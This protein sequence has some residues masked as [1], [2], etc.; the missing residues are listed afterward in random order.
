VSWKR[1]GILLI[2][3][4][5][6]IM[7]LS[8]LV[9]GLFAIEAR[10][11]IAEGET[12]NFVDV[13]RYVELALTDSSNPDFH[14]VVVVPASMLK[15]GGRI[16][17]DDLPVDI[18]V[19]WYSDNSALIDEDKAPDARGRRSPPRLAPVSNSFP[20]PRRRGPGPAS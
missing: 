15:K 18:D 1:S 7:M 14:D 4:G 2:H 8:E 13:S 9:T 10:M 5:L 12:V 11:T 16:Q 20:R 3:A 17:N 19:V 6:I